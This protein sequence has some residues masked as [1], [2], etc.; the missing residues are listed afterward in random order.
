MV[1]LHNNKTAYKIGL[2]QVWNKSSYWVVWDWIEWVLKPYSLEDTTFDLTWVDWQVFKFTIKLENSESFAI[3]Q[4]DKVQIDW[5]EYVVKD[6]K[7]YT[8]ISY[9]TKKILLVKD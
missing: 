3:K 6:Q 4:S 8:W 5:E 9:N 2:I 1:F 7:D